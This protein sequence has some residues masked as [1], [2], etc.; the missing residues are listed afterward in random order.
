MTRPTAIPTEAPPQAGSHRPAGRSVHVVH[1]IGTLDRGGAETLSLDMCRAV[2]ATEVRQTFITM[3]GRAGSLA[4]QFRAAGAAVVQVPQRPAVTFPLRL[5]RCLRRRRPDVVVSHISLFS[6]VV[7][8]VAA[9]TGVPVRIARMWSEG[10]GRRDTVAR[11]LLRA[12]LRR[13]LHVVATDIVAVSDAAMAYAGRQVGMPGCRI[14]YNSVDATRVVGSDRESARR[15]WGIPPEAMVIGYI[16]RAAPEKNRPFLVD[17][18]RAVQARTDAPGGTASPAGAAGPAGTAPPDTRLLIVG[19]CGVDDVVSAHPDVPDDPTV[20]LGGEVDE[21]APVLAAADVFVLPSHWEGLPGV[22]L[23]ALAA[24]L[25]VVA[26]DLPCLR[27]ASRYV[28]GLTLVDLSAGA[29]RWAEAVLRSARTGPADRD[30]I[31][32][33]FA[34]SPFQTRHAAAQWRSLWRAEAR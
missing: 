20:I 23:E 1:V 29:H 30:R 6:A 10:D 27:E 33:S 2:P 28:D 34:T 4:P 32:E 8:A 18:H 5:R 15:R 7:L 31:R 25:P 21:I 24:G 13:L 22:V 9:V 14:L 12:V 17:V 3:G 19:P 26:T 11:R 16:G